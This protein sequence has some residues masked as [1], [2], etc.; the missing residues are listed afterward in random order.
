MV[1]RF[2]ECPGLSKQQ[3]WRVRPAVVRKK[4]RRKLTGAMAMPGTDNRVQLDFH[5]CI[6]KIKVLQSAALLY[7]SSV[8]SNSLFVFLDRVFRPAMSH[9][10]GYGYR[11]LTNGVLSCGTGLTDQS[12]RTKVACVF[13]VSPTLLRLSIMWPVEDSQTNGQRFFTGLT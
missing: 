11:K 5:A 6:L 12:T 4:M 3:V 1:D 10:D 8:S 2:A 13:D 9:I 7:L